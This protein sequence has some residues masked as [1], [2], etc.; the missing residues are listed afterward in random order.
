MS[1]FSQQGLITTLQRLNENN[2]PQLE[3]E[4]VELARE[5]P[6][7]LVLPCHAREL[8]EPALNHLI[9]EIAGAKFLR[10]IVVSMNGLDQRSVKQAKEAF[11]R[12]PQPHRL[13]WNDSPASMDA[14]NALSHRGFATGKGFNLWAGLGLLIHEKNCMVLSALDC[15][16]TTFRR[17]MLVRLCCAC[18]HPGLGYALTKMYYPR[19]TDRL[20]GRVSRLFLAPLLQSWLRLVG[21]QPLLD[22][23]LNFR[24]PLAG[25]I[26]LTRGLAETLQIESGWGCEIGI[27][28]EA[29]RQANPRTICQ[30][31]GGLAY[32]HRHQ[33]LGDSKTG[34]TRMCRE[35]AQALFA[36]FKEEG[37]PIDVALANAVVAN[38]R[39][40]AAEA[41]ARFKKLALIN[42]IPFR[43]E[44]EQRCVESFVA[45]L[46]DAAAPEQRGD[47]TTT[48]PS[49]Q[50]LHAG[51]ATGCRAFF[52]AAEI[53]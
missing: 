41:L 33:P 14:W 24:Y 32:D 44:D 27:L 15:D 45:T 17:E 39:S 28:C 6:I 40:E 7:G 3:S 18:A 4:L 43:E 31:D 22:F 25:E 1:D 16:V 20:H 26:A 10:E 19:V 52:R 47:D 5:T 35:I 37:V 53:D 34:L 48:L 29:F 46:A 30:V 51:N 2:G 21:H 11:S 23:L 9:E 50:R 36:Q 12:L 38:Y 8:G 49:W 42:A 13:L